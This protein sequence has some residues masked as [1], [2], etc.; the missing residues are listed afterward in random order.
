MRMF[1]PPHPG[2]VLREFLGDTPISTA[3]AHLGVSRVTLSRVL[4]DHHGIS[5][6]MALRLGEALETTPESWLDMQLKYDLAQTATERRKP[7]TPLFKLA[8]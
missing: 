5:A 3:A 8:A 7:L 1:Q 4:N 2:E 6:K